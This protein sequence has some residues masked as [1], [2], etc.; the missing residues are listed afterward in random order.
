[1][2]DFELNYT[3]VFRLKIADSWTESIDDSCAREDLNW[4][5]DFNLENMTVEMIKNL[6]EFKY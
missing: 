3:P 5:N 6:K 1:M 4:K 2:P